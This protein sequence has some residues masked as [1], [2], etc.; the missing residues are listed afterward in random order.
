MGKGKK[1]LVM[2]TTHMQMYFFLTLLLSGLV[3]NSPFQLFCENIYCTDFLV[4]K[5]NHRKFWQWASA[6]SMVD[7][8]TDT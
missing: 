6:K 8:Q 2:R 3:P 4:W 5:K 7:S 1:I